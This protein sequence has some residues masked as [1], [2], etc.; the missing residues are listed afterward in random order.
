MTATAS[1]GHVRHVEPAAVAVDSESHRLRAEVALAGQAG[2]VVALHG[3]LAGA[4]VDRRNRIAIG[5]RDVK[6]L[7]IGRE[8]EGAGMRSG[9]DGIR[10][11]E[12]RQLA[13]HRAAHQIELD[14]FR[15]VPKRN[16]CALLVARYGERQWDKLRA[17]RRSRTDR[18]ASRSRRWLHR[19]APHRRRDFRQPAAFHGPPARARQ[20]P[21]GRA[22]P[23]RCPCLQAGA[24]CGPAASGATAKE[25]NARARSCQP[26]NR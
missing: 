7:L 10:R 2:V 13:R 20:S 3:K 18:S 23:R 26:M 4:H 16:K 6:G 15:R 8:G 22:R 12:Q 9:G 11:L 19:A 14:D 21:P 1:R 17:R 5:E 25:S 24:S